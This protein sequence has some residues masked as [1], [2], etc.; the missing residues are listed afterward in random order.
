MTE[1]LWRF[2]VIGLALAILTHFGM[3]A[4]YGQVT[5][6]EENKIIL[7]CEIV[8]L[9]AIIMATIVSIVRKHRRSG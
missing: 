7:V 9:V 5:I 2:V 4:Y 1:V 3:I 8:A 6:Q